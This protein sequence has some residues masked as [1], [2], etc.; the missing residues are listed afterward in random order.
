MAA[1]GTELKKQPKYQD[2]SAGVDFVSVAIEAS[3]MWGAQAMELV[4]EIGCRIAEVSYNPR[5]TSFL[6]QQI[7]MAVQ[8]G[9][10]ACIN[11]TLQVNCS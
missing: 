8:C 4:T 1:A 6:R 2:I 3:S 5:S 9:N 10:A 11:G 7:S